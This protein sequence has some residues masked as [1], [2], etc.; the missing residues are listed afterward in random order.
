MPAPTASTVDGADQLALRIQHGRHDD[1]L[2]P[3]SNVG[4]EAFGPRRT[5]PHFGLLAQQ[6][7][8][9]GIVGDAVLR[10]GDDAAGDVP[11]L[12][13][14]GEH[15]RRVEA[16]AFERDS[17]RL[18]EK[19]R[20]I[21]GGLMNL[22]DSR[23]P[24]CDCFRIGAPVRL[25][26]SRGLVLRA[27]Q[28]F[29]PHGGA[30]VCRVNLK[31]SLVEAEQRR[32]GQFDDRAQPKRSSVGELDVAMAAAVVE[33]QSVA[34]ERHADRRRGG[35][36]PFVGDLPAPIHAVARQGK[37]CRADGELLVLVAVENGN[38]PHSAVGARAFDERIG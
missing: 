3:P 32:Y 31:P 4:V 28:Q 35:R 37:P 2:P 30:V 36:V 7:Q 25:S 38:L 12:T 24:A 27:V 10:L 23:E 15:H 18:G 16:C 17:R 13:L 22:A 20:R 11:G 1:R 33:P 29:K 6:F 14:P 34:V 9:A 26:A 21:R 5:P 8:C 19:R